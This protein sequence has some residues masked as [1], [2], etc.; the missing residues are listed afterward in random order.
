MQIYNNIIQ[1]RLVYEILCVSF[2]L[3]FVTFV[4][5]YLNFT[6]M[7][8]KVPTKDTRWNLFNTLN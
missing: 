1:C 3:S 7:D 6:T 4:V 8:S 2:V 5:K